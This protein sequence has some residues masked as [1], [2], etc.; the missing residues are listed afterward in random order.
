MGSA[1][2]LARERTIVSA[3]EAY[4]FERG[5]SVSPSIEIEYR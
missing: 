5:R 4:E 2:E 3:V 1:S